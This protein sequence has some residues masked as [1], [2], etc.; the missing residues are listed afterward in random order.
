MLSLERR[1]HRIATL[2]AAAI[3]RHAERPDPIE[4]EYEDDDDDSDS[5]DSCDSD[6]PAV[7]LGWAIVWGVALLAMLA[8]CRGDV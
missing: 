3:R 2:Q 1:R 7:S 4:S 6:P 5:C 8:Q